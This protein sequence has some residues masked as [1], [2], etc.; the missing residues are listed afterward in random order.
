[1][2][3]ISLMKKEFSFYEFVGLLIPGTILLF[4]V[5]LISKHYYNSEVFDFGKVGETAI[6]LILCYSIGHVIQAMGNIYESIV[7]FV[8]KGMPS[9]W[10]TEKNSFK[11]NLF[12][13]PLNQK[14][15][16][17]SVAKYGAG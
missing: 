12:K 1:M 9:K 5:N 16:D 17:K 3:D 4:F 2:P 14:I 10:L 11:T 13:E 15:V 8:F 6:F 7:W